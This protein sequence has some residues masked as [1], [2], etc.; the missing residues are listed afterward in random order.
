MFRWGSEMKDEL[1][2]YYDMINLCFVC[3]AFS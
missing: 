3:R 1:Q 2:T